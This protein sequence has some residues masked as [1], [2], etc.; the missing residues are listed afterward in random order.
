[1]AA[2]KVY[3]GALDGCL[4]LEVA[5]QGVGDVKRPKNSYYCLLLVVAQLRYGL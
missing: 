3:W 2:E 5:S 4:E 1:M